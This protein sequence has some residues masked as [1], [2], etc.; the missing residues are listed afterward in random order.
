[1]KLTPFIVSGIIFFGLLVSGAYAWEYTNSPEFCGM[2]CH[3][4]PP[5]YTAY[6]QSPHAQ[7]KCVECHIGR[8]FIG[9]QVT[10]K[11]GDLRHVIAT[12]TKNYEY[13]ITAHTMRPAPEICER[14]HSA[15]KFSDS[16]LK[17]IVHYGTDDANTPTDNNNRGKGDRRGVFA[18]VKVCRLNW[19]ATF[20]HINFNL[21]IDSKSPTP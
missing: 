6:Q 12:V 16:T 1:M 3:S 5:E 9:N 19:S 4:M 8:E 10:R 13:P 11:A 14:C 20:G 18:P 2:A 15:N 17:T 7:I 21:R